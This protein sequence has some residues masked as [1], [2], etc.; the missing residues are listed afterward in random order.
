MS[1]N[2]S[3]FTA[4]GFRDTKRLVENTIYDRVDLENEAKKNTSVLERAAF[5]D[6]IRAASQ[7][8]SIFDNRCDLCNPFLHIIDQVE[9]TLRDTANH[10]RSRKGPADEAQ[11]SQMLVT[12]ELCAINK[13]DSSGRQ[14][15]LAGITSESTTEQDFMLEW[16]KI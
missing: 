15:Q 12:R 11:K 13:N 5:P 8:K 2:G 3:S 6:V 16:S 9:A 4:A 10:R 7:K 14:V 1:K